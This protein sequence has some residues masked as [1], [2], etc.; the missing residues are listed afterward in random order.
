[1]NK[2]PKKR[3]TDWIKNDPQ[4][5]RWWEKEFMNS[6]Q[7][8]DP[9]LSERMFKHIKEKTIGNTRTARFSRMNFLRWAA[10]ICLPLCIAFFIYNQTGFSQKLSKP[11]IVKAAKGDKVSIELPDETEII[12]NSAS[13]LSYP[14]DFG[15]KIRHVE[16]SG[17]A[18]FKVSPN[19]KFP[20]IVRAGGVEIK[21]LGTS[22]NITAYEESEETTIV[23][24][25]GKVEVYAPNEKQT[26][27]P[28]DKLK[29][30][31]MSHLITTNKVNS[32]NYIGWTTGKLY[33]ENESLKDII[34]ALTRIY[35]VK[36]HCKSEKLLKEHF[37]GTIPAGDIRK[38]LEIITLTSGFK[39]SMENSTIILTE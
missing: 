33:F 34:Q 28:G 36:I 5:Q 20:F 39:Y 15:Q 10:I 23:L 29:Y 25:D 26:M 12:L 7:E 32:S 13:R 6:G 17:E 16:L 38:A 30:N 3:I 14:N 19:E 24:L 4:L 37:T 1:M 9:E 2:R 27:L 8:I 18:Y 22:F 21:V 11:V 35:D 31:R